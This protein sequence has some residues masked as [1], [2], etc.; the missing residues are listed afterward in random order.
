MFLLP[1]ELRRIIWAQV[2]RMNAMDRLSAHLKVRRCRQCLRQIPLTQFRSLD[3]MQAN[4]PVGTDKIINIRQQLDNTDPW[5]VCY[6]TTDVPLVGVHLSISSSSQVVTCE[7]HDRK[8]VP[9]SWACSR[10][11]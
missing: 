5:C 4:V 10:H 7:F 8:V 2:R 6:T 11:F 9:G 3:M 1:L